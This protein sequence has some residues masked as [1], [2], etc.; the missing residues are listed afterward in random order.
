MK[1]I[2]MKDGRSDGGYTRI[3]GNPRLGSLVSRTHAASISAG[4]ELER[5]IDVQIPEANLSSIDEIAR[6]TTKR[7]FAIICKPERPRS[8]EMRKIISDYA[9]FDQPGFVVIEVKDG[10]TFDTQ[11]SRAMKKNL[12]TLTEYITN[13]TGYAGT[14]YVCSFNAKTRAQI[15][16]GLKGH[17][18]TDQVLTGKELCDLIDI[19]YEKIIEQRSRDQIDNFDFFVEEVEQVKDER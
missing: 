15:V 5:L 8:G 2:D 9:I 1:I 4:R 11:K 10:D 6:G 3:L 12:Q 13:R 14:F 7:E 19:S 17:F 16:H 18:S